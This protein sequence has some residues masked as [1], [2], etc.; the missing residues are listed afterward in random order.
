MLIQQIIN[1]LVLGC[2]YA[3][4]ALG[5]TLI[6]GILNMSNF[7]HGEF[8]MIGAF[9]GYWL[10]MTLGVPFFPALLIAMVVMGLI[11]IVMEHIF[12]KPMLKI[13]HNN[14]IIGS[15]GVSIILLNGAIVL[16]GPDPKRVITPYVDK[17]INILGS[18]VTQQRFYIVIITIVLIILLQL[19]IKKTKVGAAMRATAQDQEASSLMGVDI[20]VISKVTFL[21]GSA[22]AA[23]AGTLLGPV[24]LVYPQMSIA[25]VL[26]AFVVV[27]LGGLG[28]VQGAIWGGFL[29]GLVESFASGFFS[30]FYKDIIAFVIMIAVL[31]FKPEGIFGKSTIEKV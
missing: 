21:L 11:G 12:F 2:Q 22:L 19:F 5:L 23:A 14:S 17:T 6:F 10:I 1:G 4:L 20:N 31:L 26:K 7:A 9:V 16:F 25:A 18:V 8:Y 29:I 24:F 13:P 28:N 3:L 30:S 15:V 27:I